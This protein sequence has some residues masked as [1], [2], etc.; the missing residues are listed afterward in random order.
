MRS[1]AAMAALGTAAVAYL[2][3]QL[4][5]FPIAELDPILWLVAGVLV[6]APAQTA[7]PLPAVRARMA[8]VVAGAVTAALFITGVLG[9]AAD[10]A[11]GELTLAGARRAVDLRPDVVRYHLL[12]SALAAREGTLAGI[13]ESIAAADDAVDVSPH[14]PVARLAAAR[15]RSARAIATGNPSDVASAFAAW[16]ALVVDDPLCYEC[17]LGWGSAAALAGDA[18]HAEQAWR[19]AERLARPGDGRASDALARLAASGGASP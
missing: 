5:L 17:L 15:A 16:E 8:A 3:Q 10:R 14:D 1:G 11:A 4:L 2:V 9:V 6:A 12:V 18:Q 19:A 7:P 13:D